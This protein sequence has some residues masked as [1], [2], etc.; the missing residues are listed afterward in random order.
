MQKIWTAGRQ[1]TYLNLVDTHL[2]TFFEN[3]VL[4]EKNMDKTYKIIMK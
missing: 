4:R 2:N 3:C 1:N